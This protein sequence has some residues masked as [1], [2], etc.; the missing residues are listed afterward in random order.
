M[1]ASGLN[2]STYDR[3]GRSHI[4]ALADYAMRLRE[5]MKYINEHSF[6]NF[7]M[8]IGESCMK[9]VTVIHSVKMALSPSQSSC[10]SWQA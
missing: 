1:A 8:K 6:N 9:C 5:Q 2:D 7:Q 3:E 4:L 10:F